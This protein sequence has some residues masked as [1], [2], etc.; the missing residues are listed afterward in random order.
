MQHKLQALYGRDMR[1]AIAARFGLAA[2]KITF[3]NDAAAFL[4]GEVSCGSARDAVR[5]AGLTLGTGI[6]SAFAKD[7][8]ALLHG[9]GV[10]PGGEI[11]NLPY[12]GG[13][14]EDLISTRALK[15]DYAALTGKDIEVKEI[16][17]AAA[18]E[19]TARQV[20]ETFG[21]H[22]GDVIRDV[23][24]PFSPEVVVIGGGISRSSALFLP[25]AQKQA[26][27][28]LKLMPSTLLDEAN[29]RGAAFFWR[30]ES[31]P[32]DGP[33]SMTGD[34]LENGAPLSGCAPSLPPHR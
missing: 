11:W 23:I 28:G 7:G 33:V 1:S 18:G 5:A 17:A 26:G 15:A 27:A 24:A 19:S 12:K 29:L 14:V 10:P 9:E 6:G 21:L 3:V 25:M 34:P 22:L 8:H 31:S 4:L 30:E 13:T 32:T 16:A 20:F 2:E